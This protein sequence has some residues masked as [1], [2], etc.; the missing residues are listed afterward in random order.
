MTFKREGYSNASK[1][2]RKTVPG[3]LLCGFSVPYSNTLTISSP[4]YCTPTPLFR[5]SSNFSL[6]TS[7]APLNCTAFQTRK[8]FTRGKATGSSFY[9]YICLVVKRNI[10]YGIGR[11]ITVC[12]IA[13][14]CY[15]GDVSF[16]WKKWKLW[17]PVKSKPLNR[18]THNLS[19]LIMSSSRGMFVPNLVKIRSRETSGQTGETELFVWLFYLFFLGPT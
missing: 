18:L 15:N 13:Q 16:L 5:R 10:S 2:P 7:T 11:C 8:L 19:G 9:I 17:P 1:L 3:V 6:I 14:H 12:A 4:Q